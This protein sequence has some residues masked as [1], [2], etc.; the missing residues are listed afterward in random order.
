MPFQKLNLGLEKKMSEPQ[1]LDKLLL[2]NL[3]LGKV[4][5]KDEGEGSNLLI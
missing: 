2:V 5:L 1:P 3:A 4:L